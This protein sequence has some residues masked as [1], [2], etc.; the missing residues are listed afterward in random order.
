MDVTV[1]EPL[2]TDSPLLKLPNCFILPHIGS[3]TSETRRLMAERTIDN[4]IAAISD[5][6][7][8]MPSELKP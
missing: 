7:Q 2:P 8:P 6:P 3:A 1:P 4:L 5:P